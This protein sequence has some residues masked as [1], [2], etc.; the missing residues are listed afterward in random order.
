M[1]IIRVRAPVDQF[2]PL[3]DKINAEIIKRLELP[4]TSTGLYLQS[5]T[6]VYTVGNQYATEVLQWYLLHQCKCIIIIIIIIIVIIMYIP[7]AH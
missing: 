5:G 7:S 3:V 4:P 6:S 2:A 1:S